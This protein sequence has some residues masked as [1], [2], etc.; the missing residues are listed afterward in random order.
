MK[1]RIARITSPM[2][3]HGVF[4]IQKRILFFWWKMATDIVDGY[5]EDF[6]QALKIARGP[7]KPAKPIV[8]E[9]WPVTEE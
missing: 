3:R 4:V 2:N 7:R 9:T 5:F 1:L 8:L 6:H